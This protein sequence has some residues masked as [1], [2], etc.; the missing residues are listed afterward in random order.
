MAELE[1]ATGLKISEQARL[2]ARRSCVRYK[3]VI[4]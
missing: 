4:L 2:I 3:Q 1:R